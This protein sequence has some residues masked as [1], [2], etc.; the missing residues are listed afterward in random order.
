MDDPALVGRI[1]RADSSGAP[2]RCRVR[3]EPAASAMSS[4]RSRPSRSSDDQ[5]EAAVFQP[6]HVEDVDH[7]GMLDPAGAHRLLL[8]AGDDLGPRRELRLQDLDGHLRCRTGGRRRRS[9]SPFPE[10]LLIL[11]LLRSVPRVGRDR[12]VLALAP[13]TARSSSGNSGLVRRR[14]VALGATEKQKNPFLGYL[15]CGLLNSKSRRPA[16]FSK[17]TRISSEGRCATSSGKS[18]RLERPLLAG[19]GENRRHWQSLRAVA[20][21]PA[22]RRAFRLELADHR[23]DDAA[24]ADDRRDPGPSAIDQQRPPQRA[25]GRVHRLAPAP[26]DRPPEFSPRRSWGQPLEHAVSALA[27]ARIAL[28]REPQHARNG[29]TD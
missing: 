22:V 17:I 28:D 11:Y 9:P 13:A 23:A 1:E 19:R 7:V 21:N 20:T 15:V 24:V 12:G 8:K 5:E 26:A 3:R 29:A 18:H 10:A 4:D 14:P 25:R 6:P 27:P 2:A 16:S